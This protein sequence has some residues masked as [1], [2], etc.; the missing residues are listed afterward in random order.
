VKVARTKQDYETAEKEFQAAANRAPWWPAPYYNLG[1][2]QEKLR[3]PAL[4][5]CGIKP[6]AIENFEFYLEAAPGAPDAKEV[7]TKIHEIAFLNERIKRAGD[8]INQG[9]AAYKAG[10]KEDAI[11]RYRQALD[12]DQGCQ[13][14][15]LNLADALRGLDRNK[16]SILAYEEAK[17]LGPLEFNHYWALGNNYEKLE[18]LDDAI[19]AY[20]DALRTG[21]GDLRGLASVNKLLGQLYTRKGNRAKAIEHYRMAIHYNHPE[22]DILQNRIEWLKRGG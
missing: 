12:L 2:V 19:T 10:R 4:L 17:R 18:S 21:G 16:E 20:E 3:L 13:Q 9:V 8:L 22:K 14:T 15:H 6:E 7:R 1:V 5:G 11:A